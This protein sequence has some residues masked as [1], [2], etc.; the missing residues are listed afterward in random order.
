MR[1]YFS[2]C[3]FLL[4]LTGQAQA[5]DFKFTPDAAWQTIKSDYQSF[6][7][8]ERLWRATKFYG[9]G[10]VIA[11]TNIDTEFQQWHRDNVVSGTSKDVAKVAKLFG[12]KTS[13]FRLP[14]SPH[15]CRSQMRQVKPERGV[16]AQCEPI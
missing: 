14:L 9:V 10:A 2:A 16:N 13:W 6:Y 8:S 7:T 1:A 11:H 15:R 5:K 4:C 12:E 3:L